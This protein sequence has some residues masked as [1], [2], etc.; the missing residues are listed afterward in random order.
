MKSI[1]SSLWSSIGRKYLMAASGWLLGF[2]LIFHLVG[3]SFLFGGRRAFNTYADRLHS[4]GILI[5]V[6]EAGLLV[7]FVTH[8]VIAVV[9]FFENRSARPARYSAS[10]PVKIENWASRSMPY[11]GLAIFIFLLVHLANFKFGVQPATETGM[12]RRILSQPGYAVFYLAG[13]AG[14]T[15]HISH[16][17][18][19]MFQSLGLSHP[20]YDTLIRTGAVLVSLVMGTVFSLIPIL[21]M[22]KT[23]FPG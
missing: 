12:V 1:L 4:L 18:W 15:L 5:P 23:G 17:F 6:L 10:R 11:T 3:N 7:L 13:F 22:V 8:I 19:S 9:L 2:F 16:G 14:L 21:F 20:K